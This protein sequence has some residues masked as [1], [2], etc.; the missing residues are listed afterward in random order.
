M[1]KILLA[2]ALLPV[3]CFAQHFEIGVNGGFDFHSLPENNTIAHQDK[4]VLGY[5]GGACID[6]RLPHAQIGIGV[7]VAQ[8]SETNYLAPTYTLK[9]YNRVANP[10]ITPHAI[11]N[12]VW[13]HHR[14]YSYAGG[15][16]G[17]AIARVGV[18]SYYSNGS[19]VTGYS[20][21][22]NSVTGFTA[23]LQAGFVMRAGKTIGIGGEAAMRYTSFTYTPPNNP[24][25]NPYKYRL[26]YFPF[27]V[28]IR[29]II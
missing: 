6:L 16:A 19:S 24:A 14:A 25:E 2:L 7:D 29:Y 4:P 28:S 10:L 8:L 11:Y 3:S 18:N 15:M 23:G 17:L 5:A 9:I 22:Y 12:Y 13:N 20:T 1:K 21:A 26:F 27:T